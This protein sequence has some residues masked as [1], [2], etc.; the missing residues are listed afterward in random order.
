[1]NDKKEDI[2]KKWKLLQYLEN[3]DFNPK[4]DNSFE[5]LWITHQKAEKDAVK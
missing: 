4:C 5:K 1:M 3:G 2:K